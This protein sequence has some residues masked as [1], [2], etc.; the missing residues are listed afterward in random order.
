MYRYLHQVWN[1]FVY[2]FW[3]SHVYTNN[4]NN[5]YGSY[6]FLQVGEIRK[7]LRDLKFKIL[8][9]LDPDAIIEGGDVLF[10]GEI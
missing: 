2:A 4:C 8:E 7:V 10:T 1:E 5:K 6:V 3:H 9:I